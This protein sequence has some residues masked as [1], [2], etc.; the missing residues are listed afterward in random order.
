MVLDMKLA[1]DISIVEQQN[2]FISRYKERKERGK[3]PG[4]F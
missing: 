2:E 1:E 4:E 3:H